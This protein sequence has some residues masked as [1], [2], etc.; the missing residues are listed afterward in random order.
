MT[1]ILATHL[2][3]H[4]LMASD[5]RAMF[6][7]L[8][9]GKMRISHDNEI[10]LKTW[11]RG[12]IAGSGEKVF[13]DRVAEYFEEIRPKVN[14]IDP[15]YA[16]YDEL[17]KRINEGIPKLCLINN[18][19][20]FS[21]FNGKGTHLYSV[22]TDQFFE[23]ANKK[24]GDIIQPEFDI[25]E[26]WDVHATCFNIPPDMS[27]LQEFQ[28]HLKGRSEFKDDLHFM[29][30]YIIE[31]K[32]IFAHQASIDPSVTASF[33]VFFQS[34]ST[35]ESIALHIDNPLLGMPVPQNLNYWDR[36]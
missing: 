10:K 34:C 24:V 12:V 29:A 20:I 18:T 21:M 6:C 22:H 33:D 4:I 36:F 26:P 15:F 14:Q 35:G 17:Q 3:D 5:R 8:E 1:I 13:L 9:T 7:N 31:L 2:G 11:C 30:H 19:I 16:V 23:T 25:F 27:Y 28:R 32:K